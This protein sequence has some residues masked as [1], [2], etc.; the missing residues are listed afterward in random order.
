MENKNTLYAAVA[1]ER[2]DRVKR[3]DQLAI[4]REQRRRELEEQIRT[5]ELR[6]LERRLSESR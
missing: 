5:S 2:K 6:R 1:A 3:E 4:A